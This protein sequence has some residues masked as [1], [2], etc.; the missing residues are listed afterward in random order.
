MAGPS[1]ARWRPG[2]KVLV[3]DADSDVVERL[4]V[5]L[6]FHG[7]A[8]H[9]AADGLTALDRAR[10]L[11]PGAVI[12]EAA[13]PDVD[14]FELLPR[15]RAHG[16]H[17]PCVFLTS[18]ATMG[19]KLMGLT[20]GADDYVVKPFSAE[21][22]VA[23]LRAI[24]RRSRRGVEPP[25]EGVLTF[26]DLELDEETHEVRRA[27]RSV[28]LSPTEFSLLRYLVINAGTV[29]SKPMILDHVWRQGHRDDVNAVES[30]ICYLRR[31]IDSHDEHLIQTVR[32]YGYVLREAR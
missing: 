29:L 20:V 26:A 7:F 16:I 15:L 14:G 18:R 17:A 1:A 13:L 10:E 6:R 32:G 23:R 24:L 19:D 3:V 27:G 8:V 31:K 22:V 28:A 5:S 2:V 9:T 12:L 4:V 21:E 11:R 30:Y 25:G